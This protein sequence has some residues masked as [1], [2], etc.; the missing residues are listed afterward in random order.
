MLVTHHIEIRPIQ[1][2]VLFDFFL[3]FSELGYDFVQKR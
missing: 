1:G 2:H 3:L